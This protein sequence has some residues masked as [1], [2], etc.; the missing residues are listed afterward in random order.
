[1]KCC[2]L[3]GLSLSFMVRTEA[4]QQ[5]HLKFRMMFIDMTQQKGYVDV[6]GFFYGTIHSN[7]E[8]LFCLSGASRFTLQPSWQ[9]PKQL[10]SIPASRATL[11]MHE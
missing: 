4:N 6:S 5:N 9:C 3:D 1:M 7:T 8:H 11:C 10:V 2:A